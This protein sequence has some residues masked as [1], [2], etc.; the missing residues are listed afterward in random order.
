MSF[1]CIVK[2]IHASFTKMYKPVYK[3]MPIAEEHVSPCCNGCFVQVY[4]ESRN[5]WAAKCRAFADR[6]EQVNA[7]DPTSTRIFYNIS[8][9]PLPCNIVECLCY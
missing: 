2:L 7:A 6:V 5:S 1:T 8:T 4:R 9:M 3:D